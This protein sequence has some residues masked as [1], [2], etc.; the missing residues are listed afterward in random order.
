MLFPSQ[1]SLPQTPV[2]TGEE[3]QVQSLVCLAFALSK[4]YSYKWIASEAL[5]F[6]SVGR[7]GGSRT[8]LTSSAS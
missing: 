6:W 1:T 4:V 3:K 5:C 2:P 7:G 8:Q